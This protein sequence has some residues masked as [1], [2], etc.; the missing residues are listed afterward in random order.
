[1]SSLPTGTSTPVS[2]EIPVQLIPLEP[3]KKAIANL[4][5]SFEAEE[6]SDPPTPAQQEFINWVGERVKLC[7][8]IFDMTIF[9]QPSIAHVTAKG[10]TED[11]SMVYI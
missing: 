6:F 5:R 1:M 8:L 3:I 2:T 11:L 4:I 10:P 7:E 9:R